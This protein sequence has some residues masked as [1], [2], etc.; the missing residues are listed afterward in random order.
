M[1]RVPRILYRSRGCISCSLAR[2]S[3]ELFAMTGSHLYSC[4]APFVCPETRML[5]KRRSTFGSVS[6]S[7]ECG[8]NVCLF[9]DFVL[10]F[11]R[12]RH[13]AGRLAAEFTVCDNPGLLSSALNKRRKSNV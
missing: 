11:L 3:N 13:A 9:A 8:P 10:P 4:A 12:D 2:P 1:S 5:S 6:R 7:T